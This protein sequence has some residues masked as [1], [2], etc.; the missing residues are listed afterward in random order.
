ML[1]ENK[2][3]GY[4]LQL[5]NDLN[6]IKDLDLLLEKILQKARLFFNADAGSI[7]LRDNDKLK[8]SYT[9]NV[10]LQSRLKK[11]EKLI[12]KT[13]SIPINKDSIAGY[14]A[15]RCIKGEKDLILNISDVYK[16]KDTPYSFNSRFD[17]KVGYRTKSMLTVPMINQKNEL[18]GV[19][20]LINAKDEKGNVVPF[21]KEDE[22]YILQFAKAAA[23]A[24]ERAQMTRNLILRMISMAAL[25]DP[26]ETAEHVNRVG[27]YSVEIF[28]QWARKKGM[29]EDEIDKKKD[30][31]RMSAMVH[32]V[33]KVGISDKILK[34]PGRLTDEEYEIMKTHTFLGARLF[35][36]GDSDFDKA[37]VEV[38]LNHHER[39]DGKGYPGYVHPVTGKPLPGF[40]DS[41]GKARPKKGKEIPLFGRIVALAD[42]FDALSSPRCYKEPWPEEKVLKEIDRCS[43][44]QFDPEVVE[45]FFSSLPTIRSIKEKYCK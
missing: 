31:L 39:W 44:S 34:K 19:L 9:Q 15:E 37:A 30:I 13:F 12:Y 28:E 5:I 33:G 25:R 7:Y 38:T 42:V 45:A 22:P 2:K 43:G 21:A 20:Q 36:S 11:K 4:I 29:D 27:A 23:I 40:E 14:V 6:E 1:S 16:L 17:K 18:I 26:E 32:D 8:F 35:F 41:S 3:I 10:T 24:L